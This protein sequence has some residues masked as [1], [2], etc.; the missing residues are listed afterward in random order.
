L[1]GYR[2]AGSA[3]CPKGSMAAAMDR[4]GRRW[5]FKRWQVYFISTDLGADD[6]EDRYSGCDDGGSHKT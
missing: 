5:S 2:S 4:V 6:E 3:T 1:R